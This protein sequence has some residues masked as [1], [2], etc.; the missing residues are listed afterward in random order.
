M[1]TGIESGKE[2]RSGNASGS[3]SGSESGNENVNENGSGNVNV[4]GSL[5][6]L[7]ISTYDQV[8]EKLC[9]SLRLQ[10]LVISCEALCFIF[11]CRQTNT[12][13]QYV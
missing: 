1:L 9:P 12:E 4:R 7:L 10:V 13:N 6:L 2:R 8:S 3:G 11:L 5:L